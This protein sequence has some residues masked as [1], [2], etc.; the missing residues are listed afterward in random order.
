MAKSLECYKAEKETQS[1]MS[2]ACWFN[3]LVSFATAWN[4]I[5]HRELKN[6][7]FD[8]DTDSVRV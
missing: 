4:T 1:S 5:P 2:K 6:I 3:D 7:C 8:A